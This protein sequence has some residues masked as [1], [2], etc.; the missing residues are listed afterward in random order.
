LLGFWGSETVEFISCDIRL[1]AK[2]IGP[3]V[4]IGS[5]RDV[6]AS[7]LSALLISDY[8]A[9]SRSFR[10]VNTVDFGKSFDNLDPLF[11]PADFDILEP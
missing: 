11:D 3:V 1:W 2:P 7:C 5:T 10:D 4:S 6:I 9:A 8:N